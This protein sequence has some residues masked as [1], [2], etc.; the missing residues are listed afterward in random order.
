MKRFLI[1]ALI[2]VFVSLSLGQAPTSPSSEKAKTFGSSLEKYKSKGQR[3]SQ[4]N[5]KSAE[6]DEGEVIRVETDLVVNDILV[7]DQS[8]K[9]ITGLKKDDF[10][11]TDDGASQTIEIF[12]SG[13][14]PSIPRS[15]VLIIEI[16]HLELPFLKKSIQAAKL[17]VD[18]L[19]PN[20][21]MAIVTAD[22]K[23]LVDLT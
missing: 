8:G 9:I 20:D 11:V 22:V 10:V 5:G 12:A 17:L 2:P 18:K 21:K 7:A 14:N 16:N 15:I 13:E 19:N 23:L 3:V 6:P 1:I 4:E